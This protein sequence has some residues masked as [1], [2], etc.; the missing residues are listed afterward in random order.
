MRYKLIKKHELMP[1]SLRVGDMISKL[2]GQWIRVDALFDRD[3]IERSFITTAINVTDAELLNPE[4]WELERQVLYTSYDGVDVY[5]GDRYYLLN[6]NTG[7]ITPLHATKKDCTLDHFIIF[8]S[9][10]SA[11]DFIWQNRKELS[12]N[13]IK[14]WIDNKLDLPFLERYVKNQLNKQE[15]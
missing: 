12:Y 7:S 15:K 13:D 2:N 9:E 11:K 5:E 6:T 10:S 3:G 4:Y 14:Y 8:S 1:S